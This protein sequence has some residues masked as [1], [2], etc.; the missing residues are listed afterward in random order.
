MN[1]T[2]IIGLIPKECVSNLAV[3]L[4]AVLVF[5]CAT[6]IPS[7]LTL[8]SLN[9]NTGDLLYKLE[10]HKSLLPLY[11]SLKKSA[12]AERSDLLTFPAKA[13][14]DIAGLDSALKTLRDIAGKSSMLVI[15]IRP[16][17]GE[18]FK[19][20]KSLPVTMSLKGDFINLRT[21]LL[22]LGS[23][24]YVDDVEGFSIKREQYGRTLAF[25]IKIKLALL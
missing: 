17:E 6:I 16:D 9:E 25:T 23:L 11:E 8:R 15:S 14:L 2:E 4:A 12:P 18:A 21:L 24:P 5:V 10:E 13:Q 22:N 3:S 1:K 20:V 19:G 7:Y